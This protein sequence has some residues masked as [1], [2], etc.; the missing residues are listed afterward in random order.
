VV[1]PHA[2]GIGGNRCCY[3][4]PSGQ[5]RTWEWGQNYLLR[6]QSASRE[7]TLIIACLAGSDPPGTGP[8]QP[9]SERRASEAALIIACLVGSAALGNRPHLVD[10]LASGLLESMLQA[11][12]RELLLKHE[13]LV[14]ALHDEQ[15][16][17]EHDVC[18]D[19][20]H[21]PCAAAETLL[22]IS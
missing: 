13:V 9:F 10:P 22:L 6:E 19:A 3:C 5:H 20:R 4:L 1:D 14:Q 15:A 11:R 8:N 16:Q 18:A 12:L 21:Q 17:V 2:A 7:A